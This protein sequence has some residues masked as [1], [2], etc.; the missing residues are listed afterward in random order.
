MSDPQRRYGPIPKPPEEQWTQ[1]H[2]RLPREL[3]AEL[4]QWAAARGRSLSELARETL[5]RAARRDTNTRKR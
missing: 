2:L 4:Q 5:A 3:L 1:L